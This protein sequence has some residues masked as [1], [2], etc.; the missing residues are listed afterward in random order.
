M[1]SESP[2][3]IQSCPAQVQ[4][5]R[6]VGVSPVGQG[7]TRA[8]GTHL[9]DCASRASALEV[10]PVFHSSRGYM[11]LCP[12]IDFVRSYFTVPT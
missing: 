1:N 6:A 3:E 9:A 11:A 12:L 8:C 2:R 7:C 10:L 5:V 4:G